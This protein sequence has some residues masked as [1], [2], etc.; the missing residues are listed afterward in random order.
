MFIEN[1]LV[2]PVQFSSK[3]TFTEVGMVVVVTKAM[4]EN[5]TIVDSNRINSCL[6]RFH[7]YGLM[8]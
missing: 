6:I 5:G 3:L 1:I 4:S 8:T 2:L 7:P